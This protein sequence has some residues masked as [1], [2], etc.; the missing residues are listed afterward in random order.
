L[1]RCKARLF[2]KHFGAKQDFVQPL[3]VQSMTF[4]RILFEHF[5]YKVRLLFKHVGCKARLL[6]KHVGCKQLLFSNI[7]GAKQDFSSNILGAE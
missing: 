6:F 4:F 1:D 7:L 5:G 2:F 3:W